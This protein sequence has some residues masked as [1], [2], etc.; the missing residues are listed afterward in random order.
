MTKFLSIPV[1]S[2]GNQLV[3]CNDIKLIEQGSTTT[4]VITYGGGKVTTITHAA[5]ASGSEEMRDAIQSAVVTALQ[6]PWR[7]VTHQVENLP[8]AVS[9]IAIS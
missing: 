2:E 1:T 4:V 3:S 8:K 6:Q 9:A 7:N 5:S